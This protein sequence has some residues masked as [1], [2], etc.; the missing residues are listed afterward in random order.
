MDMENYAAGDVA[1]LAVRLG[2]GTSE[3]L[4]PCTGWLVA[5]TYQFGMR[6]MRHSGTRRRRSGETWRT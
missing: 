1:Y 2:H 3:T 5:P 4:V 6:E